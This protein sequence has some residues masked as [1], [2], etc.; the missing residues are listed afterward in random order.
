MSSCSESALGQRDPLYTEPY[1]DILGRVRV[2][3]R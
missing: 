3:V 1:V 2:V